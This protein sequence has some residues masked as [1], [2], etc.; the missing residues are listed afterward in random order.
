MKAQYVGDIGDFGKVLL[1]KH[2]AEIGFKISVNWVLTHND[3]TNAGE[4]RNYVNYH[5]MNCLCCCDRRLLEGIV[6]LVR[7]EKP[8]RKISDLEKLIR[9]FSK[10]TVF[11]SE[12]FDGNVARIIRDGEAFRLLTPDVADLV[13][14][15]PDNGIGGELGLSPYHVYL[16]DLRHYWDR[17]Q[18]LLIYHHLPQ[19]QFAEITINRLRE[20][21]HCFPN[22]HLKTYHFRR[23]AARVYMLCL[24]SGHFGRIDK[25]EEVEVIGPLLVTKAEW[26]KECRK[27]RESCTE[28]H[29]WYKVN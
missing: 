7:T 3:E 10:D 27:K 8:K 23:G 17:G 25:L 11:Y 1:L 28:N 22:I 26:A 5:G 16:S 13:F 2:L 15:D 21:L 19:K 24:Q 29:S 20:Q 12:Y 18:S 14:F 6:P 9:K 4:H